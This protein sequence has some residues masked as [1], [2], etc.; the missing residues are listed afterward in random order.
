MRRARRRG[1]TTERVRRLSGRPTP[2]PAASQIRN[3][4]C[5][6]RR[7]RERTVSGEA[8]RSCRHPR[9]LRGRSLS[10]KRVAHGRDVDAQACEQP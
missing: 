4:D 3:G 8:V 5:D 1:S 9:S 7:G 2:E 10:F 6:E